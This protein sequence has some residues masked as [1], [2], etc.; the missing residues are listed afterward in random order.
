[1]KKEPPRDVQLQGGHPRA[2]L[3]PSDAPSWRIGYFRMS[4]G[5]IFFEEQS[6]DAAAFAA[7]SAPKAQCSQAEIFLFSFL[8][9]EF[10]ATRFDKIL[11]V[12][13]SRSRLVP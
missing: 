13:A 12:K 5:I 8:F 6:E 9:L 1:M 10:T 7:F 11:S 3:G 4:L 2:G